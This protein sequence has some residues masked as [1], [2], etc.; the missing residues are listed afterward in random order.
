MYQLQQSHFDVCGR[1]GCVHGHR[2]ACKFDLDRTEHKLLRVNAT[3]H[4]PWAN[5]V[6]SY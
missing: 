6:V 3:A 2:L 1:I 4:M 5:K